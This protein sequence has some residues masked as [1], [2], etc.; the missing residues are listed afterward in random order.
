MRTNKRNYPILPIEVIERA[1]IGESDAIQTVLR[2]YDSYIKWASK[3]NGRIND[4]AAD[5]I[6]AKLMSAVL[7]FRMDK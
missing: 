1:I 5:R 7:K 3:I 6:R 2:R 4:E